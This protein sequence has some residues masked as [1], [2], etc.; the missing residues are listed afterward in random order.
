MSK[1]KFEIVNKEGVTF[2]ARFKV[3]ELTG[4]CGVGV[5][6]G[7]YLKKKD[8]LELINK[9]E[10]KTLNKNKLISSFMSEVN[11]AKEDGSYGR[12]IVT[13]VIPSKVTAGSSSYYDVN[14]RHNP[15]IN[16]Y[17]LINMC[18]KEGWDWKKQKAFTNPKTSNRVVSYYYD[19]L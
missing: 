9:E 8:T 11:Q 19:N 10:F 4:C 17:A 2:L 16:F 12:L 6:Y 1:Y 3:N 15:T 7:F 5:L 18:K 13:D 14:A